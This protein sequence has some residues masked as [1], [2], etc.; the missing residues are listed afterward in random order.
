[1]CVI[2]GLIVQNLALMPCERS[3]FPL[4]HPSIISGSVLLLYAGSG[5]SPFPFEME[6]VQYTDK[7]SLKIINAQKCATSFIMLKH[8]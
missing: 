8:T 2:F 6:R 3:L 5:S 1:M 4:T 7:I